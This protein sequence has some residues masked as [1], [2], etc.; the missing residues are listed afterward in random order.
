[1]RP[2]SLCFCGFRL[3]LVYGKQAPITFRKGKSKAVRII[4]KRQLCLNF[5]FYKQ[6]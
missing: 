4:Y 3:H 6:Q 5:K 1:M 2:G